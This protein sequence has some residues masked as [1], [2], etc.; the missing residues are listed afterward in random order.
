MRVMGMRQFHSAISDLVAQF[1]GPVDAHVAALVA[2][3][4][5]RE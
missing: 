1:V 5:V 2:V 3:V 4:F